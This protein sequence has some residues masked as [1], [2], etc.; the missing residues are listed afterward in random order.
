MQKI[1]VSVVVFVLLFVV[2]AC[3]K[4]SDNPPTK[5]IQDT[6]TTDIAPK[7]TDTP[8]PID[9]PAPKTAGEI[10]FPTFPPIDIPIAINNRLNQAQT[11]VQQDF[12]QLFASTDGIRLHQAECDGSGTWRGAEGEAINYGDGSGSMRGDAGEIVNYGD[13]SGSWRGH[14]GEVINYGDG[15]GIWRGPYGVIINDGNGTGTVNGQTV[16]MQ[17][18]PRLAPIAPL[19]KLD[20]LDPINAMQADKSACGFIIVLSDKVLFDF[21]K[22]DLTAKA[23]GVV[24]AL[25]HTLNRLPENPNMH[26]QVGRHTDS[27]GADDYNQALSERRAHTVKNALQQLGVRIPMTAVG[28][29]EQKPVAPNEINGKDNP[30]GRAEN[31][32]IEIFVQTQ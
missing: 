11:Q 4:K 24:Q 25:A 15:M 2:V 16:A 27:K 28:Y 6:K 3:D 10:D 19:P 14:E 9:T 13:G 22:H 20:A 18:L 7:P 8:K 5:S 29:G 12:A 21:D 31:R 1:I 32:R 17:P 23:E 26:M 30:Q